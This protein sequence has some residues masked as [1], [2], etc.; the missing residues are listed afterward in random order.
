MINPPVGLDEFG[1]TES[2]LRFEDFQ[3]F[4]WTAKAIK[5]LNGFGFYVFVVTNQPAV[6]KEKMS[7][8]EL[9]N[10]HFHLTYWVREAGGIIDKIYACLH[11]PDPKQ[12]KIPALLTECDCRK[13][14]PGMLFQAAKEFGIDLQKSWMIGDTWKDIRAGQAAGCRTIL[15]RNETDNRGKTIKPDFEAENLLEAA[16]I[17]LWEE[18]NQ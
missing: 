14:K 4:P 5:I 11:H 15:V 12:V 8:Q 10:M 3:I 1:G 6:A 13:P 16:E 7:L 9:E 17:I 2:P 18:N